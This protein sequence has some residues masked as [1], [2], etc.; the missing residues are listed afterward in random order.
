MVKHMYFKTQMGRWRHSIVCW[1]GR[2]ADAEDIRETMGSAKGVQY[3]WFE[4]VG[5]KYYRKYRYHVVAS[6][7]AQHELNLTIEADSEVSAREKV[8]E[9]FVEACG[10]GMIVSDRWEMQV[11]SS[12]E[13]PVE[14]LD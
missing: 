3:R 1:C 11:L 8:R 2:E 14:E 13:I 10:E 5:E 9:I 6:V 12:E 7:K 4:S